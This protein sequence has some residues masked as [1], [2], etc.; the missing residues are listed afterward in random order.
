MKRRNYKRSDFVC[1]DCENII[2][3]PRLLSCKR[4]R[5]HIKDL[6]CPFCNQVSKTLEIRIGDVYVKRNGNIVYV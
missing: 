3:L 5:G 1:M 4:E 2:P 6:Y